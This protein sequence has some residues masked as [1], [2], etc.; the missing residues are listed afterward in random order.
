MKPSTDRRSLLKYTLGGLAC[1]ALPPLARAARAQAPTGLT[2]LAEGLSLIDAGGS[3]VLALDAGDGL[4]LVDSGM[5][6]HAEALLET[7]K[8]LSGAGVRTLFNTHWHAEQCGANEALGQAGAH[9]SAHQKT[10]QRLATDYYLPH[11]ER[12]RRAAPEAARPDEFFFDQ[13]SMAAGDE[14]ID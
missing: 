4:V 5:P 8:R 3:N 14:R 7:L 12:Y 9:I 2:P 10:Y 1:A 6:G 13:G 11:E